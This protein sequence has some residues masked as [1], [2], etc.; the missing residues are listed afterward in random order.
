M[1]RVR[2]MQGVPAHLEYLKAKDKRRHPARC[3]YAEGK[4][5]ERICKCENNSNK[6]LLHCPSS[7]DCEYYEEE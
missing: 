5:K 2:E 6:F 1:A 3:K 4:T 7:K